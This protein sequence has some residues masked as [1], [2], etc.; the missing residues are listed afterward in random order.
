[1]KSFMATTS[2]KSGPQVFCDGDMIAPL[3]GACRKRSQQLGGRGPRINEL[4][5]PAKRATM[6]W[7]VIDGLAAR[8]AEVRHMEPEPRSEYGSKR[9]RIPTSIHL[10]RTAFLVSSTPGAQKR[11]K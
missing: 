9:S 5:P 6:T 10:T 1:M 8:I 4:G 7:F 3:G 11:T 2:S